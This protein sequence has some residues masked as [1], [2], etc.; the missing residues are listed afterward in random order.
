MIAIFQILR[1]NINDQPDKFLEHAELAVTRRHNT[2]PRKPQATSKISRNVLP[3]SLN[4]WNSLPPVI[5]SASLSQFKVCLDKHWGGIFPSQV[6]FI[7][8][9]LDEI[10]TQQAKWPFKNPIF[11]NVR[12]N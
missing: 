12:P 2:K 9:E 3:V 11:S 6:L 5:T 4:D 8:P 1:G 10:G 7:V